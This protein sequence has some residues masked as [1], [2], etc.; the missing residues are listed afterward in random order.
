MLYDAVWAVWCCAITVRWIM[1]DPWLPFAHKSCILLHTVSMFQCPKISRLS[2]TFHDFHHDFRRDLSM[3]IMTS[4]TSMTWFNLMLQGPGGAGGPSRPRRLR[5]HQA[6]KLLHVDGDQL[7]ESVARKQRRSND[8]ATCK[9]TARSAVPA[10]IVTMCKLLSSNS[11]RQS[12]QS[13]TES[14]ALREVR[15]SSWSCSA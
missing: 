11:W 12:H 8:E 10:E 6:A 13:I 7:T 5:N 14:H 15:R 9:T 3:T 1:M 2:T 4:M